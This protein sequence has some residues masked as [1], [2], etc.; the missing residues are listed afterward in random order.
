MIFRRNRKPVNGLERLHSEETFLAMLEHERLR[1]ERSQRAFALLHIGKGQRLEKME[2]VLKR[3][4]N[5]TLRRTDVAGRFRG[6]LGILL[7]ETN[8][9]GAER[10]RAKLGIDKAHCQIYVFPSEEFPEHDDRRGQQKRELV[11][12]GSGPGKPLESLMVTRESAAKRAFDITAALAG[13]VALSPI[14]LLAAALVRLTSRGPIFFTQRRAGLGG[15]PFT[16]YKFRTMVANAEA[17]KSQLRCQSEQDGPAFKMQRD[18]RITRVGR[19]LRKTCIDELPQLIN[20]LLGHMSIVGPRPLPLD[21]SM[22]VK[23]WA[24]TR[25]RVRPGLTC[26]WQVSGGRDVLF[27]DWMRMDIRY[28]RS[29]SMWQDLQLVL[30]TAYRVLMVRA[31]TG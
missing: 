1:S 28:I 15:R 7:P 3:I 20:V 24:R 26:I 17:L 9:A 21:E 2:E 4:A 6:A 13:L 10:V 11:A 14:L 22:L 30:R 31:S 19:I 8:L 23:S 12:S 16:M 5:D 18:P 25:L 27:D 29:K